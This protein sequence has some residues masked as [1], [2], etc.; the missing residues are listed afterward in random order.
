MYYQITGTEIDSDSDISADMIGIGESGT[1]RHERIQD[2]ICHMKDNG[3]DCEY[4]DVETYITK[5]NIPDLV[6]VEK[7]GYE[8]KLINTKYNFRFLCD[9]IVKYKGKYYILEIKTETAFKWNSRD[10]V[11]SSHHRQATAYALNLK[12]NDVLFL[13]EN[14]DICTKKSFIYT[15]QDYQIE[16]LIKLINSCDKFVADKVVPP[17]PMN[18]NYTSKACRYCD[19]KNRCMLES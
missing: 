2:A 15:V 18:L 6:V 9:G 1:D 17:I 4:I 5:F 7:K 13:Y 11:D 19:Y 3:I 10:D 8:T 12:I 14:R 16:E